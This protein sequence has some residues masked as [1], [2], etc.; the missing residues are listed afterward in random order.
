MSENHSSS[1][2]FLKYKDYSVKIRYEQN[3]FEFWETEILKDYFEI[4]ETPLKNIMM[5]L[6]EIFQ[7][8]RWHEHN[9]IRDNFFDTQIRAI[10]N[11]KTSTLYLTNDFEAYIIFENIDDGL[12]LFIKD[13]LVNLLEIFPQFTTIRYVDKLSNFEVLIE[14]HDFLYL[15]S[16]NIGVPPYHI[17]F[18]HHHLIIVFAN[19][20]ITLS[21]TFGKFKK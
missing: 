4:N 3:E 1:P 6:P 14:R 7:F 20:H 15:N 2:L 18:E 16:K 5:I 9:E 17:V 10:L 12:Y 21:L 8:S 11:G 19:K 13:D